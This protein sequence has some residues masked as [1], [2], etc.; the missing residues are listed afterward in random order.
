MEPKKR[1]MNVSS[2]YKLI[3]S[4][5]GEARI[6]I[7]H[8]ASTI[9]YCILKSRTKFFIEQVD[10]TKPQLGHSDEYRKIKS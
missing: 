7:W 10:V 1:N 6:S 3:I 5:I 8:K 9:Y 2:Y 4:N